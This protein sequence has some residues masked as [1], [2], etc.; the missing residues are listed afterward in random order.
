MSDHPPL[1]MFYVYVLKS[2]KNNQL[3]IGFTADLK[4]RFFEHNAGL[5]TSTKSFIPWELIYYES[6]K[7]EKD[8]REREKKLKYFKN[9]YSKLKQRI[10]FSLGI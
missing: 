3:Y 6:Y 10:K 9:S 1:S 4:R 8:A 5:S 2:L 7:S